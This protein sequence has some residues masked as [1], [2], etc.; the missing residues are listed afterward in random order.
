MAELPTIEE[1]FP[2]LV[3]VKHKGDAPGV[4]LKIMKWL[5]GRKIMIHTDFYLDMQEDAERV[6]VRF[7]KKK[8][9][10]LFKEHKK[11]IRDDEK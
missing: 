2:H 5:E 9:A 4:S 10:K 6:L 8:P 11:A 3:R 7:R 1:K